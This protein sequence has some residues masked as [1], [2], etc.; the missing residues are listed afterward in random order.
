MEGQHFLIKLLLLGDS[1]VGKSCLLMR[2]VDDKFTESFMSTIGIDFKIKIVEIEGYRV[3]LQLWDT[4]GQE[5]FDSVT[6]SYYRGSHGF[7][8]VYDVTN[9]STFEKIRK[10]MKQA[11]LNS[12]ADSSYKRLLLANKCDVDSSQRQVSVEEGSKFAEALDIPFMETS[13]KIDINVS[14]AF[15]QIAT[16]V[17]EDLTQPNQE[18]TRNNVKVVGDGND[19]GARSQ[20][21]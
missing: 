4:A 12:I 9:K 13:A 3:K 19:K 2:F 6:S 14:E 1:G 11:E 15:Y 21:C 18:Q 7:I 16:A 10:W 20:C 5:R 8:F 17:V